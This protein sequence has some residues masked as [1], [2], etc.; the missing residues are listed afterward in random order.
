MKQVEMEHGAAVG[1]EAFEVSP[2]YPVSKVKCSGCAAC[3]LV[4]ET[5]CNVSRLDPSEY[6]FGCMAGVEADC[7]GE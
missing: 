1:G 3:Y 2:A 5:F 4:T 6:Y 7:R